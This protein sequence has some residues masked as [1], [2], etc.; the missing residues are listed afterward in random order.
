VVDGGM[1]IGLGHVYQS[2]T[3]AKILMNM[4]EIIFLTKS[5]KTVVNKIQD[6]GFLTLQVSNDSE[7]L[8]FLEENKPD[9]VI[10]DKI[11]VAE[12]LANEIKKDDKI[13]L[14]I[15]TNLTNANR[16]A[17]VAVT[18]DIGS[19]FK[20][21]RYKDSQTNTQY[22]YGPKY[23]ILRKEFHEQH[24][25]NKALP[26]TVDRILVIFGGSDPSNLTTLVVKELLNLPKYIK[27]DVILGASFGNHDSLN[28]VL[29]EYEVTN[30]DIHIHKDVAYVAELM[31]KADLVIA[32]PGLSAFEALYVGTPIIIVPQDLLQK[33]T[34][35]GFFKVIDQEKITNL[36]DYIVN[37]NFTYPNQEDIINMNIAGGT[38]ELIQ[39]IIGDEY[40]VD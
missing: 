31:Y 18:A 26:K 21:I 5:D 12:T 33:E 2:I 11:D 8:R 37:R 6:A 22:F 34:Y 13:K 28:Q 35:Q 24:K 27:I 7:I 29:M 25:K 1:K 30:R 39:E 23:W 4:A 10:I 32:S 16:Y 20:N 3:F 19:N 14:V 38:E 40:N 17:D 15:F 36:M 9:I